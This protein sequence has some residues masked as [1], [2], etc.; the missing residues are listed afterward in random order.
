MTKPVGYENQQIPAY[1]GITINITS[2]TLNAAPITNCPPHVCNEY[3]NHPP[4]QN[5]TTNPNQNPN[6]PYTY[7]IYNQS[8]YSQGYNGEVQKQTQ[9]TQSQ[10]SSQNR[11]LESVQSNNTSSKNV[12]EVSQAEQVNTIKE[13]VVK[14]KE[15]V[16]Q[17]VSNAQKTEAVSENT[18]TSSQYQGLQVQQ[19]EQSQQ[20]QQAYPA[21]YYL[22]NYNYI[23]DGK[24]VT[25][26]ESN[27]PQNPMYENAKQAYAMPNGGQFN[28]NLMEEDM[29]SS[30]E[31]ISDIEARE[32]EQKE[33]EKN[34]KKTRVI[35]LTN[36]YIMSLENY[37]NNPNT[38]IRLMAAKEVLTRLD[39]DKDRYNDVALNAL[40]NKMLQDP[41][42]LVRIAAL[43]AFSS[44]LASGNDF[45][46]RLLTDI[47]RNPNSD[48]EDVLEAADILLK[49][50]ATTEIRYT[51]VQ[52][53]NVVQEQKVE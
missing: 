43:S 9:D 37:L 53:N 49:R 40:L 26:S 23:Q 50:S 27:I 1:S 14:E 30:K 31:I 24:P 2:P 28:N 7:S 39:E 35:A 29:S 34:G 12:S 11:E 32:A 22:N 17:D 47:Q 20:G 52:N 36:E 33:L 6:N 25:V 3:C 5:Y 42:K 18:K 21:Q 48:K 38:E 10:L 13:T 45:T 15:T 41:E 19:S 46:V 44:Q 51:P 8:A 16:I 4:V